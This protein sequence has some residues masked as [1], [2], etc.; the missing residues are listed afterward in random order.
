LNAGTSRNK[1]LGGSEGRA[2]IVWM[3][4]SLPPRRHWERGWSHLE[5]EAPPGPTRA[6][7]AM[8]VRAGA[9]VAGCRASPR[10]TSTAAD[11]TAVPGG[12][13]APSL[14]QAEF[15]WSTF[16]YPLSS[17][18][19]ARWGGWGGGLIG[20]LWRS[21]RGGGRIRGPVIGQREAFAGPVRAVAPC[22]AFSAST[23][24][25]VL[26]ENGGRRPESGIEKGGSKQQ[27]SA[28]K[29]MTPR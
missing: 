5:P 18:L 10:T 2:G 16:I 6:P 15:S 4:P 12:G 13:G 28:K 21:G 3:L 11:P 14:C 20:W 19:L 22:F 26:R 17:G 29:T 27:Y 7:R 23:A 25:C 9:R 24:A 1:P 8:P